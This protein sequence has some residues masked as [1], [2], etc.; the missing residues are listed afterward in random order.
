M[1]HSSIY[2]ALIIGSGPNGLS[3]AITL[4]R[5]GL[6]VK[7][8]EAKAT[9]GGGMRSAELTEPG[10]LHDVCSAAFPMAAASPFFQSL[11][12]EQLEV[13]WIH[14][15]AVLAHPL[16]NGHSVSLQ[17]NTFLQD[18]G[19]TQDQDAWESIF[20]PWAI[21]KSP[22]FSD[23]LSPLSVPQHPYRMLRFG[24]QGIRSADDFAKHKFSSEMAKALFAGLAGHSFLSFD[25]FFSTAAA[26]VLAYAGQTVGWPIV[27][28]G[29]QA[30]ANALTGY[31]Q[32][33]GG[34]IET[35][36]VVNSLEELPKCPITLL[37][38][39]VNQFVKIAGNKLSESYKG[40]LFGFKPG[41][42]VFK[43]DWALS[44]PVPWKSEECRL[45][46]TLHIGGNYNEIAVAEKQVSQGIVPE[47]PFVL[48]GQPSLFDATRCPNGKHTL[49]GYCHVPLGCTV[50]M[51]KYIEDQIERF[52][53]GFRDCIISKHAMNPQ[54]F[55]S[56]NANYGG[57]DI[58]GGAMNGR[59]LF[60]R[61]TSWYK[62][63]KTSIA[64][65]YLCSASTPPGSG[66]H[67]MCG[68]HAANLALR[69]MVQ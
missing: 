42:G 4:A 52:A 16:D 69:E 17:Q 43:V 55:E 32:S 36:A 15:P 18:F 48:A 47:K 6:K 30:L 45:A 51:T 3:A 11:P 54:D 7:I 64:G 66:V 67:G 57:G 27:R 24:L 28:G 46:A 19:S 21:S 20:K 37:D 59:Q 2:D 25:R 41:P 31:F 56:H 14:S 1:P 44:Q 50:D 23:F 39:S 40:K 10:F 35:N 63:Y 49:W 62:P 29:A 58:S 26:L 12:L 22:L 38:V 13:Q 8:F 5:A 9:A 68:V 60:I 34:E 65:T 61:P 53:P 33:L